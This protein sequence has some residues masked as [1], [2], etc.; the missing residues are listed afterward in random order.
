MARR[1]Q[2]KVQ[3]VWEH[4]RKIP[5]EDPSAVIFKKKKKKRGS[6]WEGKILQK[7]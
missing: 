1:A 5:L 4:R 7:V 6:E 3:G 2:R